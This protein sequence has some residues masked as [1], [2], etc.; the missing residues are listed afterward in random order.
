[1]R[2]REFQWSAQDY[3]T[4]GRETQDQRLSL[5]SFRDQARHC[6]WFSVMDLDPWYE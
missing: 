5:P 2:L 1:M 6:Y 4:L 3:S